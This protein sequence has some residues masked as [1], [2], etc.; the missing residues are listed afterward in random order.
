MPIPLRVLDDETQN[1]L[2]EKG[3]KIVLG[4]TNFFM[5]RLGLSISSR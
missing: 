2:V 4:W 5:G 1:R 3:E